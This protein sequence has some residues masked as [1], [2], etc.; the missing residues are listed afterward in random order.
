MARKGARKRSKAGDNKTGG[1]RAGRKTAGSDPHA[2]WPDDIIVF[3]RD[4]TCATC[5]TLIRKNGSIRMDGERALCLPCA[6]LGQL[7]F[8]PSGDVALTRRARKHSTLQAIVVRFSRRRRRYERQGVLVEQTGL[9]QAKRECLADA[10][11]RELARERAAKRRVIVDTR[12][13]KEFARRLGDLFPGC[14]PAEREV[15]AKHA[16]E[17]YS[18]RIGRSAAAQELD[19]EVIRVAVHA[20]IRHNHTRY[21]Q[22]LASGKARKRARSAVHDAV[23]SVAERW[24]VKGV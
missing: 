21:D 3:Q 20:H 22:L 10:P 19:P 14:P 4:A 11:A 7:V 17:K 23:K 13:V 16:C 15:I 6:G 24:R 8:L 5:G 12:Y 18:G 9:E 2:Q 1:N